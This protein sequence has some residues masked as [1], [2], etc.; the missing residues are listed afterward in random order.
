MHTVGATVTNFTYVSNDD[1]ANEPTAPRPAEEAAFVDSWFDEADA[2]DAEPEDAVI[3]LIA[4]AEIAVV[5]EVVP[6]EVDVDPPADDVSD[7]APDCECLG[8]RWSAFQPVPVTEGPLAGKAF[9][10]HAGQR[11]VG[12]GGPTSDSERV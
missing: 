6:E 4:E 10:F 5:P 2:A 1:P 11:D 7:H 8:C 12:D 9:Y 3:D